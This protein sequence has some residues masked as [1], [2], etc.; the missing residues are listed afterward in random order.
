[1]LTAQEALQRLREGRCCFVAGYSRE[2][3]DVEQFDAD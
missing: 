3:G 2:P 1:M